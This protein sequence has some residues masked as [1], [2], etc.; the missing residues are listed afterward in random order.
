MTG[1]LI[2]PSKL[3]DKPGGQSLKLEAEKICSNKKVKF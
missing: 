3:L 2:R 1:L